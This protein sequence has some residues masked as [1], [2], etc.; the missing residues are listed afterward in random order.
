MRAAVSVVIPTLNAA[1]GLPGCLAAL[2]EGVEAGVVRELIIADGGS[3]DATLTIADEVGA[4]VVHAR[5]SRGG[6][7]R[8]GAAAAQGEWLLFLHADSVLA[9]GWSAV[10]L[11][12]V[13]AGDQAAGFFRLR[14]DTVDWRARLVAGWAN[15]RSGWAGLPFGDQGLLIARDLYDRVGGFADIPL[16]EDVAMARAL[17]RG[18]LTMLEATLRTSAGRYER[19][20]WLRRG[21]RNLGLQLRFFSGVSP[22]RLAERYRR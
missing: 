5:A 7:L 18:R 12:H 16:M 13:A 14:F 19:E 8:Q 9:P 10:V 20:G 17:G 22:E 3:D 4:R 2:M 11:A 1:A 6:Q 15:L 21:A